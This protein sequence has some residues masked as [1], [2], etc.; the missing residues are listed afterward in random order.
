MHDKFAHVTPKAPEMNMQ[1][2]IA[3]WGTEGVPR[4]LTALGE[5]LNA[6]AYEVVKE[7]ATD[8]TAALKHYDDQAWN[9]R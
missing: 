9:S 4:M 8:L 3:K 7:M 1:R 6:D 2:F 5:S